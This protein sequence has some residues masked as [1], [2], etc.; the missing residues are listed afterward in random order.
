MAD[1]TK[2][3]EETTNAIDAFTKSQTA[4]VDELDRRLS[5]TETV[6]ART[7]KGFSGDAGGVEHKALKSWLRTGKD[8]DTKTLSVTNDGQGVTVREDWRDQIFKLVREFSPMRQVA[9]VLATQ[10]NEIEVLV[11]R[12]EPASDWVAEVAPRDATAA[13]FLTRHKIAVHEHYALPSS[14][15]QLLED[16][17]FDVE[18]WLQDKIGSRFGRQEAAAFMVGDGNGQ[19]RGILD[20]DFVPDADHTWGAD[21]ATYEI[22]AVYTGVD[23]GLP[24]DDSDAIDSLMDLVDSLKAP[25]LP[26]ARF[27]MTRAMRNRIRKLKDAE[28]RPLLQPSLAEGVPDRL[29]GYPIMLSEDMPA[30]TA[31]APGVLFGNFSQAYSIVDRIG[32]AIVRDIYSQPGFVRWYVRRRVGG[33]MTNPE[34]VKV[35]VLGS[36]PE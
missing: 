33:A 13:A 23:G 20:Y 27:M 2:M 28:A 6:M 14:T 8:L 4:R 12:D 19:P 34:A 31:D 9:N 30:L 22:G 21:P 29:L 18:A 5:Q 3:I 10:S 32:V 17:D 7:R 11:D 16:S 26:G 24:A 25:Y 36:E 1:V 15:L 35:L